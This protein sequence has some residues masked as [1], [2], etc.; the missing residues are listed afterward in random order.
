MVGT[1]DRDRTRF[2]EQGRRLCG[3]AAADQRGRQQASAGDTFEDGTD[4]IRMLDRFGQQWQR[5][6]PVTSS[7]AR[8]PTREPNGTAT[9]ISS[10]ARP[11]MPR[12]LVGAVPGRSMSLIA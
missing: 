11:T 7:V 3:L 4:P 2:I 10:P 12:T 8:V 9:V 1:L 6:S 5:Q